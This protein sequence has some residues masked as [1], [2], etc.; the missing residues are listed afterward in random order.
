MM[1]LPT[2]R[3][4]LALTPFHA[5]STRNAVTPRAPESFAPVRAK[6]I[7]PS[8]WSAAVIEVFSPLRT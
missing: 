2:S 5:V 3:K 6:T 1:R 7:S 4:R 8:D